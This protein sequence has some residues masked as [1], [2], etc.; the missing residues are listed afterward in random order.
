MTH[1]KIAL[2]LA[3]NRILIAGVAVLG[4]F[5]PLELH[6]VTKNTVM[7]IDLRKSQQMSTDPRT[8]TP[9]KCN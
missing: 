9:L 3:N 8:K 5:Y 4:Y 6:F 1:L 7:L 2:L